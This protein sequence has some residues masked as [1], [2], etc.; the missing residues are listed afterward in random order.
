MPGFEVFDNVEANYQGSGRWYSGII[1][2]V[3]PGARESCYDVA[4]DDGDSE[5]YVRA[6]D[7]RAPSF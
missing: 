1:V 3:H 2:Q 4:Y 7:L 5:A 6:A